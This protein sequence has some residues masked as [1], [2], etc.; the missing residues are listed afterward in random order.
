MQFLLGRYGKA[1]F[2]YTCTWTYGYLFI[3]SNVKTISVIYNHF[4]LTCHKILFN[5]FIVLHLVP[6][7][8]SLLIYELLYTKSYKLNLNTHLD[9]SNF[10]FCQSMSSY[11]TVNILFCICI[12]VCTLNRPMYNFIHIILVLI[13]SFDDVAYNFV[14]YLF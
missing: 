13:F 6:D 3:S 7:W 10:H 14:N 1:T 5:D 12:Y 11:I 2:T 9:S 4:I 8:L